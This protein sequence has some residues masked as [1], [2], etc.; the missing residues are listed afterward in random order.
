MI[1]GH[2]LED[3][4]I[5]NYT[6]VMNGKLGA[7]DVATI[8]YIRRHIFLI[9]AQKCGKTRKNGFLVFHS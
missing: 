7:R 3:A 2:L 8:V 5:L 6:T 4:R 9:G 1:V